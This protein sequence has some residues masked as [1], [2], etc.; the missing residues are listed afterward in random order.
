MIGGVF[1]ATNSASTSNTILTPQIASVDIEVLNI[2][3]GIST[4]VGSNPTLTIPT[5]IYLFAGASCCNFTSGFSLSPNKGFT[6]VNSVVLT[7][8]YAPACTFYTGCIGPVTGFSSETNHHSPQTLSANGLQNSATVSG[9]ISPA[10]LR[11][12]ANTINVGLVPGSAS[13]YI[14]QVRLTVE[15]TFL[16]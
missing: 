16:A 11:P 9:S 8:I 6:K 14:Y 13:T 1:A 3:P 7:I 5:G 2:V 4:A 15:Y 12:G 10:D